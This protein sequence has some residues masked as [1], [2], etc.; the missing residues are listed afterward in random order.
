VT[1]MPRGDTHGTTE[2][3]VGRN[4]WSGPVV[5]V[6]PYLGDEGVVGTTDGAMILRWVQAGVNRP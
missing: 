6:V 3:N 2:M 5:P 1:V 4:P